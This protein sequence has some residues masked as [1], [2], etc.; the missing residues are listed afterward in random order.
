[1]LPKNISNTCGQ[2]SSGAVKF[3][4]SQ[5]GQH[6]PAAV[7]RARL[8]PGL[9]APTLRSGR[10]GGKTSTPKTNTKY[11]LLRRP[12]PPPPTPL[13]LEHSGIL[14]SLTCL[15]AYLLIYCLF[16]YNWPRNHF[17]PQ[18]KTRFGKIKLDQHK[19][20]F[21]PTGA[22]ILSSFNVRGGGGGAP[23]ALKSLV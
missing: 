1:M 18:F 3:A 10:A 12:P 2:L 7:L 14:N 19:M 4:L 5:S 17:C 21:F 15:L 13:V 9:P 6:L 23:L 22:F 8:A 20:D 11:L 16:I